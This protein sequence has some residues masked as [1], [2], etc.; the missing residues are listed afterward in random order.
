M[1]VD[2]SGEMVTPIRSQTSARKVF[3]CCFVTAHHSGGLKAQQAARFCCGSL[4]STRNTS[5]M[6]D[7]EIDL[8]PR[9]QGGVHEWPPRKKLRLNRSA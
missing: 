9:T 6:I 1:L 4:L 7:S 8:T 2:V 3:R 5:R